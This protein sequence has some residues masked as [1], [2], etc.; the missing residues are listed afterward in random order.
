MLGLG[1]IYPVYTTVKATTRP[2]TLL[3]PS[4]VE[5]PAPMARNMAVMHMVAAK[6]MAQ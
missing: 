2:E 5:K 3:A 6:M 4:K 1:I